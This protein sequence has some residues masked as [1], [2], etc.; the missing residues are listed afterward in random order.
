MGRGLPLACILVLVGSGSQALAQTPTL[1]VQAPPAPNLPVQTPTLPSLKS[2]PPPSL[3]PPPP[4][5]RV[6]TPSV[7]TPSAQTP[8]VQTPSVQTPSVKAPSVQTPSVG[9]VTNTVGSATKKVSG[10]LGGGQLTTGASGAGGVDLSASGTAGGGASGTSS[11]ARGPRAP[12]GGASRAETARDRPVRASRRA[13]KTRSEGAKRGG[14][15]LS[16]SLA[17]PA[18]VRFR[19]RLEAPDCRFVG[20]FTMRAHAG[21]NRI[22]FP[23]RIRGKELSPGTYGISAFAV[24]GD[25]V[26]PLGRIR[27]VVVPPGADVRSARPAP[28]ACTGPREGFYGT[29]ASAL[30]ADGDRISPAG[31]AGEDDE[32]GHVAGVAASGTKSSSA[33]AV[34]RR[35]RSTREDRLLGVVASPFDDAPAW[36]QPLA[37][38]AM[39]VALVLLLLAALPGAV[40]RRGEI[41]ALVGKRRAEL[42]TVGATLL[43]A[44]VV[45][46]LVV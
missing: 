42:A 23:G 31:G 17:K 34:D 37:L 24:H 39:G 10:S 11:D 27:V 41:A 18:L 36:L 38:W 35:E 32:G 19:V 25:R 43:A 1:P 5:P 12:G 6:Q 21:L 26:R 3:P 40:L 16:F 20:S 4:P 14:I 33:E 30:P 46:A 28:A 44:V 7:Q 15:V 2:P 22:R 8:S 13:F 9:N 45:A 29:A